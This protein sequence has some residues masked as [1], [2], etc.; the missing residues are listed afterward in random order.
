[1]A[2]TTSAGAQRLIHWSK[3]DNGQRLFLYLILSPTI[4]KLIC[5]HYGHST[6]EFGMCGI[7]GVYPERLP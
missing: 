5:W 6:D 1:M 7:C 3:D 2:L 4:R